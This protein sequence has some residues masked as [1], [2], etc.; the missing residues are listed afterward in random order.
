MN[1]RILVVLLA[2]SA[3][4]RS[5][6]V[7]CG[8]GR[9]C[10]PGNTCDDTNHRC[11]SPDQMAAC[12]GHT[13]GAMCEFAGVTGTCQDG[14]CQPLLCGDGVIS[15]QE[16]CDGADL[17]GA[18]CTTAGFYDPAGLACTTFCTFDTQSCKGFCGDKVVNGHELC[19]GPPPAGTCVDN[20][21]DAGPLRCSSS[22]GASFERC[23]RFGWNGTPLDL[24]LAL[25]IA[26][27]SSNDVWVVG[28]AGRAWHF[29]G[30]TWTERDVGLSEALLGIGESAANDVWAVSA[31]HAFHWDG[32]AW[33]TRAD[34]PSATYAT[35]WAASGVA[36]IAT[37]D[38]G[39]LGWNGSTWQAL[40]TF[41]G[42]AIRAISGTSASDVWAGTA[43]SG[44]WHW[45]GSSWRAM[46]AG[47]VNGVTALAPDDVWAIGLDAS[48][49]PFV[50]H[51][52]GASWTSH[53][54]VAFRGQL[55]MVFASGPDDVWV[56]AAAELFHF[57][58]TSFTSVTLGIVSGWSGGVELSP[59]N[60]FA[61]T[62]DGA[63][64]RFR[65]QTWFTNDTGDA[66]LAVGF[67]RLGPDDIFLA[68]R[69]GQVAHFDGTA[70]TPGSSTIAPSASGMWASPDGELYAA[71]G[72]NVYRYDAMT[73]TWPKVYSGG[74]TLGGIWGSGPNDIWV[75]GNGVFVHF[76]GTT[77][78]SS[79][80]MFN[81]PSGSGTG[82]NDVWAA[83]QTGVIH[84]NGTAW[85]PAPGYPGTKTNAIVALAPDDVFAIDDSF[86]YHWDGLTW[87]TERVPA[88][89]NLELLAATAH[90]D[91][92]AATSTELF[93]FDGAE[94]SPIRP[95]ALPT[96]CSAATLSATP[97]RI[98][99]TY[100]CLVDD[101][102]ASLLRVE[103]L[104]CETSETSCS[105]GVDNDC[106]GKVDASDPPGC[107]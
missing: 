44:I 104:V 81:C 57:D 86:A 65:G 78:Q 9:I 100:H 51:W 17:G 91:V 88:F 33:T 53:T 14:T 37:S 5:Q 36:D 30:G 49:Q 90:D 13:A 52:D 15:G 26:A 69:N 89:G 77:W 95:A 3:C 99:V 60:I 43:S 66:A 7:L 29:D 54:D 82:L 79:N 25:G 58:G 48:F 20:G 71:A 96:G 56:N 47:L 27:T 28:D 80:E 72:G 83:C 1:A 93:Q 31:H 68:D 45:D 22:C 42:G 10:P 46:L 41:T 87:S 23:A 63:I 74:S 2:L 6:E 101:Q 73:A 98:D 38:H 59:G 39:V 70:W 105:D 35:V 102:V 75:F 92:I 67:A 62:F 103:P 106:N 94:W 24:A 50:A 97:A 64:Y 40:G 16:E 107:P 34:V 85:Q 8:D 32:T 84:W 4:T 55:G 21:F 11:I 18:D 12:S 61:I 76:D 19:D